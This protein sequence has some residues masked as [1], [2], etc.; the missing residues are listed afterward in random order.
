MSSLPSDSWSTSQLVEFLAAVAPQSDETSARQVAV[1]RVLES[2]DAEVGLLLDDREVIT[3]VG[4]RPTVEQVDA[5]LGAARDG[6][7]V[8]LDRIGDCRAA[9]VD[10]DSGGDALRLLV[11]RVGTEEFVPEE[12]LLLRG[13]AWVLHLVLRPLRVMVT[14]S[15]R[16]RVLEAVA[17]VQRAIA[18]RAPL[19]EVFDTV[20]ESALGLFGTELAMLYLADQGILLMASISTVAEE[21]RPPAWRVRLQTSIGRAAYTT[22]ELVRTDNYPESQYAHPELVGRGARAAMAAPVRENGVIVGSLVTFSFQPGQVFTDL[23]EQTLLTFADQVSVAL[24]DA[25]TLA[26]AQ[27]A[28][29]DPVTGLPN[30]VYFLERLEQALTR[31]VKAHVLFLDLDRFKMVN[32]TLGHSAG[33]ELL[34]QVGTRLR[35]AIETANCLARF[36]GD[37]YAVLTED[38]DPDEVR[39]L[40][41]RM[42]AAVE[43]PFL[44]RGEEVT[45][46]ASIGIA[47]NH[48]GALAGDVLRDADTAMYRAK[49]S[50]HGPYVMFEEQMRAGLSERVETEVALRRGLERYE[51]DV[52]YQ[53]LIDLTDG[54]VTGVEALA[55]W[56]HPDRG[57]LPPD[58]FIPVAEDTGLIVPLGMMV[59]AVACRDAVEWSHEHPEHPPLSVAV[60]ISAQQL[61]RPEFVAG[62]HEILA[63]SELEPSQLCLELTESRLLSA[64]GPGLPTLRGLKDL[65]V[66]FAVDDFGTGYSP[67]TYLRTLPVDVLKIDRSFV[68]GFSSKGDAA[69]D[70][71]IVRSVI[72][73]ANAFGL[74]TIAEGVET[75]AQL[76]ALNALGCAQAQGYYWSRPVPFR[77]LARWMERTGR[78]RETVGGRAFGSDEATIEP[79]GQL[80]VL[81]IDD[82]ARLRSVLSGLIDDEANCAVVGDA[83][84]GREGVVLARRHRP[85][86]IV[87]DMAMPGM[88]GLES[89]PLLRAVAPKAWIIVI[90]SLDSEDIWHEARRLGADDFWM[91]GTNFDLLLDMIRRVSQTR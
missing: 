22:G 60:N 90:T 78:L 29:R 42:L 30:R 59:L 1:E 81:L 76:G 39:R 89:L 71:A 31:G 62:V 7:P 8:H 40:A 46:G 47:V 15:E 61:V 72:D 83:A 5:M 66:Q 84:D 9:V 34:R 67:L 57:L 80:S 48:D 77:D 28:R 11:A 4:L 18:T 10:L 19:P 24:S 63:H 87:L 82:D 91:K 27:H 75:E 51:M 85:D 32:D 26:T 68:A 14:L 37:E 74:T 53:P 3:A 70:R 13:M 88:G 69:G 45:V 17:R 36:G 73:L 65:G 86:V 33:D 38:D 21:Y 52:H 56:N 16:Q 23:Q 25:K 41:E 2:L 54:A 49:E 79:V 43:A 58:E 50:V 35:D 20:T 6:P 64:V 55:R 12:M 44:V